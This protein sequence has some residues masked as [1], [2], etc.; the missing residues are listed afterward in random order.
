MKKF[1]FDLTYFNPKDVLECGQVFRFEKYKDGYFAMSADKACYVYTDHN[2]TVVECDDPD[3][4]YNYFDL[5]REYASIIEEISKFN[6]PA[7]T[8][9]C[10]IAKG[11]RLLNQHPEETL[12]SFIISQNNNIPRIKGI[13]SRICSSLG[14]K[15]EFDGKEYF[16]FPT[17]SVLA[18]KDAA[19]YK[20]LGLGY[21]DEFIVKTAQR[22]ASEGISHLYGLDAPALKKQLLTYH[23]VGPKV[24]DCVC[25][26]GFH[27]AAS[28][29]VD[30]WVEKI[31]R[32]DFGGTLTNR[33]KINVYFTSLFGEYSG[34]VQQY[35]FYAK[36]ENL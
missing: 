31:Y 14:E 20:G 17:A 28:F 18:T 19:F 2:K 29:P 5:G 8:R 25:L 35:L 27:K 23:G 33:E 3:Y 1:D 11:L 10:G 7:L 12:F 13:I 24:A 22:I 36:R 16:T 15:R 6:V 32:E 9:A 4:F 21:R 26:F 34:Y 30:T